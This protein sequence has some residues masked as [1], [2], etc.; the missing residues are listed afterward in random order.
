MRKKHN[1]LTKRELLKD[2]AIV[3]IVGALSPL[4]SIAYP[5]PR[6]KGLIAVENSKNR[7]YRLATHFCQVC[8][9]PFQFH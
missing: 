6:K 9:P 1:Q 5:S 2:T 3:G 8:K 7:Y 4:S